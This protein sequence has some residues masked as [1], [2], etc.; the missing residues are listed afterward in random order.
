MILCLCKY[1]SIQLWKIVL[2]KN[3]YSRNIH[4]MV[5]HK[6]I[7]EQYRII[8]LWFIKIISYLLKMPGACI[9]SCGYLG[10]GDSSYFF[11]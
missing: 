11:S 5:L 8:A 6:K 3:I 10:M 7:Q 1:N 2:W 9:P 4:D